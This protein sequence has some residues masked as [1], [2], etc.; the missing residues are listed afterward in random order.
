M[1]L[2][3][4]DSI[5]QLEKELHKIDKDEVSELFLGNIRRDRNERRKDVMMR[6]DLA[7]SAYGWLTRDI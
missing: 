4:Q 6:L 5:C 2:H 1:L 7:F 3:K